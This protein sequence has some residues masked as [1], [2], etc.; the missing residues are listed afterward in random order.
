M[1][2]VAPLLLAAHTYIKHLG[3]W[4]KYQNPLSL[5]TRPNLNLARCEISNFY[6]WVAGQLTIYLSTYE[7]QL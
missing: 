3:I 5:C 6:I 4:D 2:I 1:I 7:F